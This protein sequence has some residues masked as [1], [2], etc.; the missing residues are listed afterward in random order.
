[1]RARLHCSSCHPLS[2]A[3]LQARLTALPRGLSHPPSTKAR[4]PVPQP[5]QHRHLLYSNSSS[6][7]SPPLLQ[8]YHKPLLLVLPL[9]VL[10]PL[11]V[12]VL[13]LAEPLAWL[14]WQLEGLQMQSAAPCHTNPPTPHQLPLPPLMLPTHKLHLGGARG[15][16]LGW[17]PMR[18]PC[19]CCTAPAAQSSCQMLCHASTCAWCASH[20]VKRQSISISSSSMCRVRCFMKHKQGRGPLQ[21]CRRRQVTRRGCCQLSCAG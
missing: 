1:M 16:H 7:D 2:Y 3:K 19:A 21:E 8:Q 20:D 11:V 13:L 5:L 17:H 14:T 6:T 18:G 10:L 9:L 15:W 12:P 4:P